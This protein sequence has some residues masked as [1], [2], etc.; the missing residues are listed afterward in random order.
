MKKQNIIIVLIIVIAIILIFSFFNSDFY[1]LKTLYLNPI[2]IN[3][4]YNNYI[5]DEYIDHIGIIFYE[6]NDKEVVIPEVI[7]GKKVYSI[8]DS[9]F[10]GNAVM[11][12]VVIPK[13]VI[14]IGHQ[15]FI[16][17]NKLTL[18]DFLNVFFFLLKLYLYLANIHNLKTNY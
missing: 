16:G 9:A 10:Y 17:N 5:V 7:N 13:N 6:G 15:A 11:E 3:E 4:V 1:R 2:K 8:E 14:R 12:K 18:F